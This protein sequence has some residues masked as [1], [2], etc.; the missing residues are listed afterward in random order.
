MAEQNATVAAELARLR[1]AYLEKIPLEIGELVNL[2]TGL[3][4]PVEARPLLEALHQR[5]HKL[6]GSGATFGLKALGSE[7]HALERTVQAWL[8]ADFGA[9]DAPQR[10][11]FAAAVAALVGTL[12]QGKARA[13][14]TMAADREVPVDAEHRVKVWLVEDDRPLGETLARLLGQFG[15]DVRLFT[16]IDAAE[17]ATRTERP[18]VLVMDVLFTDEGANATEVLLDRPTLQAVGCP[19]LFV[20]AHGDFQSRVRAARLGAEGFL[21]KPLDVPRLVDHIERT[22]EARF[23]TPYRVLIVDDDVDLAQHFKLVLSAA[24]MEV[25]VLNQPEAV[26]EAVSAF[27]PEL[28]LMDMHMPGYSG[29]ELATVIRHYDEWIGLPIVY[30]SA[31]TDRDRQLQAMDRGADEFI[32]KPISDTH[33]VTA[34]RARATRSR[35][36]S[37]LMSKDSL[38]GLLKHA[39]IKET[40]AIELARAQRSGKPLSVSMLDIDHFKSVNDTYGHAVGDR[41]IKALA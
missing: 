36:L 33:L 1:A 40:I 12:D 10:Q 15:Y 22:L 38:T 19:I 37:D 23:A 2:A 18:D 16:R 3:T 27:R 8:A 9:V 35:Q 28:V 17:A 29:P 31:E 14:I 4:G 7:A 26:I 41:V 13:D 11:D 6:A 39:R 34:V 24:G 20:S 5:L 21:L 25:A 32:T 30:L